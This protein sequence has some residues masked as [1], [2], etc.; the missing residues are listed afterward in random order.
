MGRLWYER[1]DLQRAK[2]NFQR[3][4]DAGMQVR[5]GL[6]IFSSQVGLAKV[7]IAQN[8]Y[9]LA[10]EKLE[11]LEKKIEAPGFNWTWQH[12]PLEAA[13]AHLWLDI[14]QIRRAERLIDPIIESLS[15]TT[16]PRYWY[17]QIRIAQSRI[18]LARKAADK[19]LE[20]LTILA[21]D[22]KTVQRINS[23]ISIYLFQVQA[24]DMLGEEQL[25]VETL[26]RAVAI[27][28]P[29]GYIRSFVD[30][31]EVIR[32]NL[33]QLQNYRQN[34]DYIKQILQA[35]PQAMQ[36][37]TNTPQLVEPLTNREQ[38]LLEL[39]A[40][41]ITNRDIAE[42]LYISYATVRRHLNNIYGKLAVNSRSQA[43]LRAQELNLV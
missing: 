32:I 20:L 34:A 16:F 33:Q 12:I 8:N 23:L 43:I 1:N 15:I 13:I 10:V 14:G 29:A 40:T 3:G 2:L 42:Q 39:I 35:F 24:L 31:G 26:H 37:D 28:E 11:V 25:A 36:L 4:L 19:S 30:G 21:E 5:N 7:Y 27:A 9:E 41:G 6:I 17:E 22:A 18:L 38:E